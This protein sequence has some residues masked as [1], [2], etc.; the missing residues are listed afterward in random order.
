MDGPKIEGQGIL[1]LRWK[2]ILKKCL[3]TFLFSWEF[4]LVNA[5]KIIFFFKKLCGGFEFEL[6]WRLN[7][8]HFKIKINLHDLFLEHDFKKIF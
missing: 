7:K 1:Q 8:E 5:L 4:E 2:E 3:I 6:N